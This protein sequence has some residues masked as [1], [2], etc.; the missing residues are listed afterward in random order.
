MENFLRTVAALNDESR[1]RILKFLLVRGESCVCELEHAL[2]MIQS[3]LS[4]HLK[5]LKEADFLTLERRGTW[6]YYSIAPDLSKLHRRALK[7]IGSLIL[8]VPE[9]TSACQL[10]KEEKSA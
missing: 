5:I 9:K 6:A 4:R 1:V 8:E 7:E 2:G 3:R 10:K